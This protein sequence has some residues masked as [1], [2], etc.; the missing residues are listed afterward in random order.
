LEHQDSQ[1]LLA[2]IIIII[3]IIIIDMFRPGENPWWLK[4]LKKLPNLFGSAPYT[5]AS[6]HQ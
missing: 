5:L 1:R 4:K 6:C 2:I 3:I